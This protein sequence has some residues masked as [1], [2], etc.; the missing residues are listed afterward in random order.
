MYL[1]EISKNDGVNEK[2]FV[3]VLLCG[4]PSS[5]KSY[6]LR[7]VVNSVKNDIN[8]EKYYF[9]EK[10]LTYFKHQYD[11]YIKELYCN[12][13]ESFQQFYETINHSEMQKRFYENVMIEFNKNVVNSPNHSNGFIMFV[14]DNFPICSSRK[15]FYKFIKNLIKNEL[16]KKLDKTF[17]NSF[18][19]L[20]IIFKTNLDLCLNINKN[21]NF[22][23]RIK[24]E[25]IVSQNNIFEYKGISEKLHFINIEL[26]KNEYGKLEY[27]DLKNNR[28]INGINDYYKEIY[29][30]S[31]LNNKILKSM[32]D[33]EL[34]KENMLVLNFNQNKS[35][36]SEFLDELEIS[37]KKAVENYI[38]QNKI[39]DKVMLKN[40]SNTKKQFYSKL[41]NEYK[42]IINKDNKKD[43]IEKSVVE[44]IKEI[45]KNKD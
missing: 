34:I 45:C 11:E 1:M 40:I 18:S 36:F 24:N 7:N 39:N 25:I 23:L 14:E 2:L 5:G 38:K 27:R 13:K 16:S 29:E 6:F 42:L 15:V 44:F 17:S 19:F 28:L 37:L 4:I 8:V 31:I 22:E 35:S 10:K 9:M 12:K 21:R 32:I 3:L 33:E 26:V 30:I 20:E 43:M 41:K